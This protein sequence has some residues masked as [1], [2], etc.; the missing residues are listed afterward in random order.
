MKFGSWCHD[1]NETIV[2]IHSLFSADWE[3]APAI[4]RLT[5]SASFHMLTPTLEPDD[6][7]DID[8]CAS[9][10]AQ[11]IQ[12]EAKGGQAHIIGLSIGAHIALHFLNSFP[13]LVRTVILSG[14][15]NF[16]P[17]LRPVA[18]LVIYMV[19]RRQCRRTGVPL[20]SLRES[21]AMFRIV[22][23]PIQIFKASVRTLIMAGL[24]EDSSKSPLFLKKVISG[25]ERIDVI[26]SLYKGHL[27]NR[28]HGKEFS[29]LLIAWIKG[30]KHWTDS[31]NGNFHGLSACSSE[32]IA[33]TTCII[34]SFFSKLTFD[35]RTY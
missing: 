28:C 16:S 26:G 18:P 22:S 4:L 8:R 31:L 20:F 17:L 13:E 9:A 32:M 30:G 15:N 6:F 29:D 10:L 14:Y 35:L 34:K 7:L 27:W 24:L 2:F 11:H 12:K 23:S 3:W 33:A 5:E 25:G 19:R 21:R 1:G